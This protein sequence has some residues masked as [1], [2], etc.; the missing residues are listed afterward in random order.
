MIGGY[1]VVLAMNRLGVPYVAALALAFIF[2]AAISVV[3]ERFLYKRLYRAPE[4]D[5]VRFTIA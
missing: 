5:Q 2:T 1:V 3:F 4:L